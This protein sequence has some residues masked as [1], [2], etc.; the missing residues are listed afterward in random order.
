MGGR[1]V[2]R[3]PSARGAVRFN[4]LLLLLLLFLLLL[5]LPL[6]LVKPSVSQAE[7]RLVGACLRERPGSGSWAAKPSI[8]R[9]KRRCTTSTCSKTPRKSSS[10]LH[11]QGRHVICYL[12]AGTWEEW[13]S[14][15]SE[16]PKSVLGSVV[17]GYP[18]RALAGHQQ[19]VGDRADHEST[20]GN[21]QAEGLRR[22][23][24]GQRRRVRTRNRLPADAPP[25][26]S[27][28]TSGSRKPPTRSG[29]RSP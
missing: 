18:E 20:P 11:A 25:S 13:R 1:P 2:G 21:V 9:W 15:A 19:P 28:T 4:V 5:L 17:K 3:M 27:P 24:G 26:S 22:R 29:S 6:A 8:S 23:R 14:D 16:F 7:S 12:D 10:S